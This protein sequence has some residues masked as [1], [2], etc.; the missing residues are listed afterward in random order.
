MNDAPLLDLDRRE[1]RS[2]FGRAAE[3]YDRAAVLQREIADSLV[4][5]LDLIKLAPRHV[6]DVG[7]GTGYGTRALAR[8]Y[9]RARIVGLDLS[10]AMAR[11]ARGPRR[12]W[13]GR[14]RRRD[15][16]LCGDAERLPLAD[17]SIDL[18]F[19]NL[20]LQWC[21]LDAAFAEFARVLRPGGLLMFT[22]FGPDT[23]KELRAAWGAVDDAPHVHDFI[24]MHDVGDALV[25]ARFRDPVMDVE[26]LTRSFPDV[27]AVLAELKALGAHNA[28]RG[29]PRALTGKRRFARFEA[30]YAAQAGAGGRVPASYEVVYGHAW[31]PA[32]DTGSRARADGTVAVPVHRIARRGA[33]R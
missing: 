15:R 22:S 10:P 13:L 7:S 25:R 2:A 32:A 11:A 19:S 26:R 21:R 31:A 20:T 30:A 16:Y 29:R 18:V 33:L 24:D 23:L 12:G 27:R 6:L 8:R 28:A 3:S 5:R 17:A 1:V 9:P 14:W 4:A